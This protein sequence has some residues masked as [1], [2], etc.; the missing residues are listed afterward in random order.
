MADVSWIC[1]CIVV[2][3]G[4]ELGVMAVKGQVICVLN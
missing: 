2:M 3:P 4:T 1:W